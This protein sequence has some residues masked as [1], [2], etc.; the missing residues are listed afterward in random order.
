MPRIG[1]PAAQASELAP[2]GTHLGVLYGIVEHGTQSSTFGDDVTRRQELRLT[3]ELPDEL[4]GDGRP[5]VIGRTFNF[6]SHPNSNLLQAIE[7]MLG[8]QL[9]GAEIAELDLAS[10]IGN[11]AVLAIRHQTSGTGRQYAALLSLSP[12][13]KG[14]EKRRATVNPPLLFSFAAFDAAAFNALPRWEREI[15]EKAPEYRAA[16]KGGAPPLANVAARMH[17]M[18]KGKPTVPQKEAADDLDDEIPF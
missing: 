10:L 9:S 2:T 7:G 13:P 1:F 11:V 6:S 12:P 5:Y 17:R 4:M 14:V 16:G 18:L 15:V 3:F 8:R